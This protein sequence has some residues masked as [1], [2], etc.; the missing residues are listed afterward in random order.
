MIAGPLPF[1]QVAENAVGMPA[2][3]CSTEKPSDLSL[4][5][6]H[7]DERYSRHAVSARFQIW[8]FQ[9]DQSGWRR[10]TQSKAVCFS[11]GSACLCI[12]HPTG[13]NP[14]ASSGGGRDAPA[15]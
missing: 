2:E 9:R 3:P 10:S 14:I 8:A 1:D 7:S 12:D 13:L 5:A 6:Y 4:S 15:C 11:A